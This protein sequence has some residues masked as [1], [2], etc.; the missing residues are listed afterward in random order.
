MEVDGAAMGA[1]L[2]FAVGD[3]GSLVLEWLGS[4]IERI[5]LIGAR[6]GLTGATPGLG[7]S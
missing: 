6:S 1:L 4:D 5:E 3:R 2:E 7:L